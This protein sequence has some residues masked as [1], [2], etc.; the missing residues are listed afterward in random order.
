M[1]F[2]DVIF[3]GLVTDFAAKEE[4][5][6]VDKDSED[7]ENEVEKAED[8]MNENSDTK[9]SMSIDKREIDIKQ[10]TDK[11]KDKAKIKNNGVLTYEESLQKKDECNEPFL[12][13]DSNGHRFTYNS[14]NDWRK[15]LSMHEILLTISN[16]KDKA[17]D[18]L[19]ERIE[20]EP[21]IA[22]DW[23][24]RTRCGNDSSSPYQFRWELR[25]YFARI[26]KMLIKSDRIILEIPLPEIVDETQT[27]R[28]AKRKAYWARKVFYQIILFLKMFN[29]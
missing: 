12:G 21:N 18:I 17:M 4:D 6:T 10:E 9:V 24:S 23:N 1:I 28:Q 25:K 8:K 2:Y 13:L 29:T 7:S 22:K 26:Q 16:D 27:P 19:L 3:I 11:T 14:H 5:G 15:M 20:K